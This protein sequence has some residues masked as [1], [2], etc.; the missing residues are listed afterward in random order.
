MD[1]RTNSITCNRASY[2]DFTATAWV[3]AAKRCFSSFGN[4]AVFLIGA[5]IIAAAIE[6]TAFIKNS[7]KISKLF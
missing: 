1:Y 4:Q 6:N 5:F 7:F 3:N 2:N